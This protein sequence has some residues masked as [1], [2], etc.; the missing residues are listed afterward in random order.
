MQVQELI[1]RLQQLPP[2]ADVVTVVNSAGG[3]HYSPVTEPI[4]T[5]AHP[6]TGQPDLEGCYFPPEASGKPEIEAHTVV[7]I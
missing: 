5:K 3:I 2:Y 7:I 4:V 6:I 1:K